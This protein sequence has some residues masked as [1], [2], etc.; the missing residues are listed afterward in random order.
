M[1]IKFTVGNY[2]VFKEKSTLDLRAASISEHS[3]SHVFHLETEKLLKSVSV[4]GKNAAG[5]SKLI[6]ALEF[7][8]EFVI[9]SSKDKQANEAIKADPFR[10][11]TATKNSPCFFEIE[12]LLEKIKYRYGFEVTK[13]QVKKEWLLER[14]KT[15]EYPL[16]LRIGEDFEVDYKR[17]SEGKDKQSW[18]RE[19]ALFL[20]LVAQLNGTLSKKII[21]WFEKIVF[22]HHLCGCEDGFDNFTAELIEKGKYKGKIVEMIKNA[23]VDIKDIEVVKFE[24]SKKLKTGKIVESYDESMV[25]KTYHE[26]YDENNQQVGL[27][28]FDLDED[29]SQGT[30]RYFNL[31]G[32]IVDAFNEGEIIVMDE[33]D[34]RLHTKLTQSILKEFN[35]RDN[36]NAQL[37]FTTHNTNLLNKDLM[38]RDQ[39]YFVEKDQYAASRLYS[40]AEFKVRKDNNYELNYLKGRYGAIPFINENQ[41]GKKKKPRA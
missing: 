32:Y 30:K 14:K 39:I 23:D 12:F 41:N 2:K 13:N 19:N 9:A 38:R 11:N 20:S 10:L 37:I 5:K 25:V 3:E 36:N 18:T 24:N 16:F 28:D 7:M 1:L 35:S 4:F 22:V 8:Q 26:L 40:L 27:E 31:V 34:A 17:F 29:E 33:L 21:S 15:K 6:D